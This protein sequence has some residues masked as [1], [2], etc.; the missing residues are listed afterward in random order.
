MSCRIG[1]SGETDFAGWRDR[2]RALLAAQVLPERIV[3][4]V[5]DGGDLFAAN[6]ALPPPV[7]GAAPA[8]V[9]RRFIE[10]AETVVLHSDKQRFARLYRVLWRLRGEPKLM[11]LAIDP[12]VATLDAM[13]KA[14]RRDIHKM[15]AFVR[16]RRTELDGA[17]WYV[18]W[19]E[20]MHH[21]VEANAPFFQR[22]FTAM[23]WSILTPERSAHWDGQDLSLGPGC[24]RRDAP[25]GDA[26]EDLWRDYYASIFNPA[27][28]KV[29]A[30][31]KE[32]PVKYWKNLPEARLIGSL[33]AQA[34]V[35]SAHMVAEGPTAP[36]PNP[37]RLAAAAAMATPVAG[38]IEELR[39][40]LAGCRACRLWQPATQAVCGAGP[41][42]APVMF[43]GEQPGDHEDIEGKPFIGPA[44]QMFDRAMAEA[45]LDRQRSY[46]T[47]AVKHFKYVPRGKRRLHQ[48]P[49]SGEIRV[50]HSWLK[51]EIDLVQPRLLVLLGATAAQ[52]VLGKAVPIGKNRGHVFDLDGRQALITVHPSYL[53]RLPDEQ[54]K[55]AEYAR[56]V[57]DLRLAKPFFASRAAA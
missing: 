36:K 46:V 45:G 53:L 6:D 32:M 30:M 1:L 29:D 20:P 52:S 4:T 40:A 24:A 18:A 44:G 17:D 41:L 2:A 10:L 39:A 12:D 8:I 11:E 7:A 22:R 16:F 27:R 56:F 31:R 33:V 57:A 23:H 43:V 47:N 5:D 13:A 42:D 3:W 14:V 28:L 21:I 9:P 26:L 55:T 15:R 38:S 50:C 37:Q 51:R 25:A 54:A 49:D 35:R 48:R 34:Q 19:F